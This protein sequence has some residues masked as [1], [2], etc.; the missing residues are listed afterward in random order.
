MKTLN[1]EFKVNLNS[2][3]S[4]QKKQWINRLILLIF[5]VCLIVIGTLAGYFQGEEPKWSHL[6]YLDNNH[7]KKLFAVKETGLS[8]PGWEIKEKTK[9][10]ISDKDWLVQEMVKNEQQVI[11]FLLP[12]TYYKDHPGVEWTDL[13]NLRGWKSDSYQKMKFKTDNGNTV[14][15]L[16]LRS[17]NP[18]QTFAVLE[19]YAWKSGGSFAPKKWFWNDLMAQLKQDRAVWAA[20]CVRIPIKPLGNISSVSQQMENIAKEIHKTLQKDLLTN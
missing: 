5:F 14:E 18:Q 12:Q 6:V 10:T 7:I 4:N 2:T 1:S 9:V 11:L 16:F 8:V 15:G 3:K 19:W 17:W 20:V 13:N